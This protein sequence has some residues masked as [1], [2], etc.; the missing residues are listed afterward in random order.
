[1]TESYVVTFFLGS[2]RLQR[3][4]H[5]LAYG[6]VYSEVHFSETPHY[7]I[8]ET[9]VRD[10][11]SNSRVFDATSPVDAAE[12]YITGGIKSIIDRLNTNT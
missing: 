10:D 4:S 2:G 12:P 7:H 6:E 3:V 1:M 8:C 11:S 9:Y 5:L